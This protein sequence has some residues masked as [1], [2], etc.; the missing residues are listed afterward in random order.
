MWCYGRNMNK[1]DANRNFTSAEIKIKKVG[2]EIRII[3]IFEESKRKELLD[4]EV[5][6]NKY[7]NENEI[8]NNCTIKINDEKIGFKYLYEFKKEGTYKIVYSFT[9]NIKNVAFMFNK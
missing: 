7:K 5:D 6:E 9:N 3:N 8:K 1:N 4:F 2:I